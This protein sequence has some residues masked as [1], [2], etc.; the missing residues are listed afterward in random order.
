MDTSARFP[1]PRTNEARSRLALLV[2]AMRTLVLLGACC[3]VS[4]V[5]VSPAHTPPP[6]A[7][8]AALSRRAAAAETAALAL[9]AGDDAA[10][11]DLFVKLPGRARPCR[12]GWYGADAGAT[13][14]TDC[15]RARRCTGRCLFT[16]APFLRLS[17]CLAAIALV[18]G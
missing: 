4:C 13:N 11:T 17:V 3:S 16:S 1:V 8:A 6:S 12:A 7:A 2:G 14:Y 18:V 10:G 15:V 5:R 9:A